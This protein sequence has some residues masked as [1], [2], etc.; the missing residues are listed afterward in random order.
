MSPK[1]NKGIF[2]LALVCALSFGMA[3]SGF[4]AN[5]AADNDYPPYGPRLSKEQIEETRKIFSENYAGMEATRKALTAKRAELDAQLASPTPDKAKIE[6]LSRE[7]GELRGKMLAARVDV[8]TQLE[9]RGLPTD[10]YGP[11]PRGDGGPR[12]HHGRGHGHWH[13]GWGRG[14]CGMMGMGMMMDGYG[15]GYPCW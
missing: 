13:G 4:A 6:S 11:G 2:V 5:D 10:F 7:I 3:G 1:M 8:R 15:P 9:K 14:G 12:W